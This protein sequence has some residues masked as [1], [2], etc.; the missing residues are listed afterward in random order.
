MPTFCPPTMDVFPA[1]LSRCLGRPVTPGDIMP[2]TGGTYNA[3]YRVVLPEGSVVLKI[4]PPPQRPTLRYE[5]HAMQV[6]ARAM[7]L[8]RAH[9]RAPLPDLLG[10]DF[11]RTLLPTD[12]LVMS[13]LPGRPLDQQRALLSAEERVAVDRQ[14]GR[15]LR[16]L[17]EATGPAFGHLL[18]E[19]RQHPRWRAAFNVLVEDVLEDARQAGVPLPVSEIHDVL[20]CHSP[21][22][23]SVTRP[24][25]LLWD[26]WDGNVF[27]EVGG[28]T[29]H[30]TGFTDFERA[31]WGD[32]LAESQLFMRREHAAFAE[33]YGRDLLNTPE[34][35]LRRG[36]YDLHLLLV[37]VVE[38]T[39][40]T[41]G[42]DSYEDWARKQLVRVLKELQ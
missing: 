42:A 24:A 15:H 22:L 32:P 31:L 37:M 41:L 28:Q 26:S 20:N 21:L 8:A 14:I 19:D 25:L 2:L 29:P 38:C 6:E 12:A 13:F 39:Y 9:T 7:H 11:S 30:L 36:L 18:D 35:R 10:T 16:A 40:R 17:H 1:L 33:G 5:R 4:A 23:D 3:A 27:V 34:D